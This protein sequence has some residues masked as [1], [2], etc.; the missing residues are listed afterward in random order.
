M[1]CPSPAPLKKK[2]KEKEEEIVRKRK[3]KEKEVEEEEGEKKKEGE[4]E[5]EE[6]K[7]E[8]EE[9]KRR[10]CLG[11][12][13]KNFHRVEA[14]DGYWGWGG[15]GRREQSAALPGRGLHGASFSPGPLVPGPGLAHSGG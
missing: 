13:M 3:R 8:K 6:E 14:E 2:K 1:P 11:H 7:E 4:R 15:R 5:K 10:S 12:P 9:E